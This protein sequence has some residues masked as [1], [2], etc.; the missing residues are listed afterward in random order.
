MLEHRI[1]FVIQSLLLQ[2]L[3]HLLGT[4]LIEPRLAELRLEAFDDLR[5]IGETV[6]FIIN[7]WN[8]QLR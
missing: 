8:S 6:L 2:Y 3:D 5:E 1:Q 4:L 7:K